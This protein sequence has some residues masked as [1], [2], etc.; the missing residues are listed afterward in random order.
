MYFSINV[1]EISTK[2]KV[3]LDTVESKNLAVNIAPSSEEEY[4]KLDR[5]M[6][7][8]L[9]IVEGDIY[10]EPPDYRAIVYSTLQ[11]SI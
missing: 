4:A 11:L 1:S 5:L 9:F 6:D 7:I 2:S 3:I 10:M 8:I